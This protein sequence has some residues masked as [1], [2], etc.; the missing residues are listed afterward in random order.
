MPSVSNP[1]GGVIIAD[2]LEI[3]IATI[4]QEGSR[5]TLDVKRIGG[6]WAGTLSGTELAGTWTQ[7]PFVGPLRFHR[8]Q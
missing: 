4:A 1:T 3:P 6:S 7:G 2:G 8:S 5:V